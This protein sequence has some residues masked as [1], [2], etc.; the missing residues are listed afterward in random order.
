M[1]KV[2]EVLEV[3]LCIRRSS[4]SLEMEDFMIYKYEMACK[5]AGLTEEQIA[6]IRQVFDSDYK[7]LDRRQKAKERYGIGWISVTDLSGANEEADFDLED[8]D[9]NVEEEVLHRM[10]LCELRNYMQDLPD[11]DRVFLYDCFS[12]RPDNLKWVTEKYGMKREQVKYRRR[13]LIQLLRE[14]FEGKK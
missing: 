5:E 4:V 10:S 7:R 1:G 3:R 2:K 14:R 12:D 13:K 11:E 8:T 9:T 6:K